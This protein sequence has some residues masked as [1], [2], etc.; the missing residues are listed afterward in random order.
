VEPELTTEEIGFLNENSAINGCFQLLKRRCIDD[1]DVDKR[2]MHLVDAARK[3]Y[4]N[5]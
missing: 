3:K 4:T 5:K 2:P 1:I